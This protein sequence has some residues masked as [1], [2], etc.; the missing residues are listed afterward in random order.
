MPRKTIKPSISHIAR[1]LRQFRNAARYMVRGEPRTED[2]AYL[3]VRLQVVSG[4][5]WALHTGDACYD[6]DHHG[7]WGADSIPLR[8][9]FDSMSLARTLWNQAVDMAV[10]GWDGEDDEVL[11]YSHPRVSAHAR[12]VIRTALHR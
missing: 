7:V 5:A 6:T 11:A 4:G 8:G 10:D 9:R 12:Q 3:E 1:L 2:N